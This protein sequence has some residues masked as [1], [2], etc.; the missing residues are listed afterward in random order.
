MKLKSVTA[1]FAQVI[2]GLNVGHL[3]ERVIQRSKR[4]ILDTLGVGFLGTSTE[5][6]HK[7]SEYSKIYSTNMT[8]TVWGR[9]D[10]R[11]P[12]TYAAFANGVA[13]HSMDF[14]D[15]WHPATHPSGAVLPVLMALSEALPPSPKFSGLD[16]LLAFN[17]GI[18]V[19]GRLM[20]FS[21][22]ANDIPKR[23]HPPSVVGTLGSAAAASKIL[24]L[25]MT[26]CQEALAIAVSHAGAPMANA[27]TQ[28][29]PLHIGNAARHGM[30]AVFLAMLG[31]QGNKQVLDIQAG[32]G[33]FYANYSPK[34]PPS[35]DSYTWLL[36]QQ[37][38]AFKRF[39]A[40]LATHW[41]E[42][43]AASVRKHLVTDRALLPVD[44]I[45]RIVLRI[46]DVQYVNRPFPVTEHEA[47]HSFQYVAC[48]TLLD[49]GI[50]VP[51]FH[52]RQINR[53]QVRELLGKVELQHPQ[54]NLPSFNTLYCEISVT[55]KDGVTFTERSNTFYGHWRKPLSQKDLQE[56]FRAN[57]S[58]MLSPDT[59]E[60]FIEIVE[61]LEDLEDC[62]LL[63]T[64]LKGP[65]PP[66]MVS[67]SI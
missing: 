57:A 38:V 11:L 6:F 13:I 51:S 52:K 49:G 65:A 21:K 12:P 44:H 53:P 35:L 17:V 34:V 42:D 5:V 58:R 55:L 41:M 25:S 63:T 16:F 29:K 47:R 33:A 56:K 7:A 10:F 30:E 27:A 40:H 20:H 26:K 15:T 66:E 24:G 28:T 64:L 67:K 37:D 2:H 9:P 43:A 22:E 3:T 23:F 46:P 48:A 1:S 39:P 19:Q 60:R 4:M 61:N 45:D 18:E 36:E 31:L 59:V 32:F 8:S 62:S 54:D 50:I 14:D